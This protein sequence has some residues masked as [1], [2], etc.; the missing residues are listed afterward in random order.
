MG[1][2]AG[3]TSPVGEAGLCEAIC[4]SERELGGQMTPSGSA[5]E[6]RREA[7]ADLRS[8]LADRL[9]ASRLTGLLPRL[10]ESGAA[11]VAGALVGWAKAQPAAELAE[12]LSQA[13]RRLLRL[14]ELPAERRWAYFR[15]L[16]AAVLE[17]LPVREHE[18]LSRRLAPL[19]LADARPALAAPGPARPGDPHPAGSRRLTLILDRLDASAGEPDRRLA[20]LVKEALLTATLAAESVP[21]LARTL[22]DLRQ[23]GLIADTEELVRALVQALPP[24]P[25]PDLTA[26][27]APAVAALERVVSLAP[28]AQEALRRVQ[29]LVAAGAAAFNSGALD[30][31]EVVFALVERLVDRR[32]VRADALEPLRAS[33]HERLDLDRL[34]RLLEGEDRREIPRALLRF[35][36]VFD[37]NALLEKL[38]REPLRQRRGVLLAL[39]EAHGQDGR[40]AV[41]ERL[42]RRPDELQDL[43]LLRNLVH[44][45]RRIPGAERRWT[46][47]HELARVVRLLVPEHPPFLVREVLAY[48]AD[49]RHPVAE[50]VLCRFLATL[51]DQL[52]ALP[53][54]EDRGERQQWLVY[55]DETCAALARLRT[56]GAWGALVEHGLRLE[57]QLG[58]ASR[59]L[60]PLAP[61]N[62]AG[63]PALVARLVEAARAEL[64]RGLLARLS[65]EQDERLRHLVAALA[66]TRS[67]EVHELLE[68]LA[69]RFPDESVGRRAERSLAS[70]AGAG[71]GEGAALSGDLRAFAFPT[72]LQNLADSAV[73]GVLRLLDGQ[74]QRQASVELERGRLAKARYGRLSGAEA[75]YQ[76]LERPV[77]GTFAF[78]PRKPAAARG[79]TPTSEITP[80]L[81]EGLRREDEL[82]RASLLVPD[83]ARFE[84]T[85]LP[86]RA[87]PGEEDID[88][89]ISLWERAVGGATPSECEIAV[90]AD[91]HRVRRC[92]MSWLED[93]A[94]R[95]KAAR[96]S[97]PRP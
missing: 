71:E 34:G 89:V 13:F 86:P 32:L 11:A 46:E 49:R 83:D 74:G 43:F 41:F 15:E 39:L 56:T 35:F 57:P 5:D 10:D 69:E 19:L 40:Q 63:E 42:S 37:P 90:V 8:C 67:P 78:L 29:A 3:P 79:A 91:A 47:E 58:S 21:E 87:I 9:P 82:R 66:G 28:D 20:A 30:R 18:G 51:E 59:R 84:A 64:P 72:L 62:L 38:H 17:R 60:T 65:T 27:G 97:R 24:W 1:R 31:T 33:G 12:N 70:V 45:L 22:R 36:H 7:I 16:A 92:L 54:G 76:L 6:A 80:L 77:R 61:E 96:P 88:L 94:L 23:R 68:T 50:Q 26:R 44:L 93:G 85:G 48:L 53:A 14:G 52:L 55:L 2:G 81:L 95:S 25:L 4:L 73:T 75:V